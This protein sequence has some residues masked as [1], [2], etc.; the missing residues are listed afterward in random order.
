MAQ[1]VREVESA[2]G[3]EHRSLLPEEE[4][5]IKAARRGIY[6]RTPINRGQKLEPHLLA[7]R[8]P[9]SPISAD[10]IDR[11]VGSTARVDIEAEEALRWD[12]LVND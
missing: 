8:R 11:V 10:E 5:L 3:T 7:V 2:L 4:P 9:N 1:G 12:L 6:A